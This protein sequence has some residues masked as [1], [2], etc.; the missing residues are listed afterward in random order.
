MFEQ[1][2]K[3]DTVFSRNVF[4]S[5]VWKNK[6][7]VQRC[8]RLTRGGFSPQIVHGAVNVVE[9]HIASAVRAPGGRRRGQ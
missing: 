3:H 7:R 1:L 9:A 2:P 4:G 6:H 5:S 8:C